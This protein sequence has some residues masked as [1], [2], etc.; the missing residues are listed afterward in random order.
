MNRNADE[1]HLIPCKTGGDFPVWF[2]RER[3][4]RDFIAAW[5]AY[6]TDFSQDP[7]LTKKIEARVSKRGYLVVADINQLIGKADT[8]AESPPTC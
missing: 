2:N 8:G 5:E 3:F 7:E 4:A 6:R 1:P